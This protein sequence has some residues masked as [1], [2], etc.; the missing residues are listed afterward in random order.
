MTTTTTA[1]KLKS[2]IYSLFQA[3]NTQFI[4]KSMRHVETIDN[5]DNTDYRLRREKNNE[6]VRK[7]RAK[8]RE[9]LQEC[10]THVQELREENVEL[11]KTLGTLQSELYTLKNL[12]QHCLSFN[13]NNLPFSPNQIPTSTFY[14]LI[15][16]KDQA[17]SSSQPS[18]TD[19][20]KFYIN[21]IKAAASSHKNNEN[22]QINT[23]TKT[24]EQLVIANSNKS[25]PMLDHDYSAKTL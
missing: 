3:Q 7:S 12:F 20:E 25:S 17:S 23:N 16:N 18:Y 9:K 4:Q 19:T 10:A 11:N 14:K 13:V 8:N 15:M 1:M 6:S 21:Q 22:Q 2:I 24:N 5:N